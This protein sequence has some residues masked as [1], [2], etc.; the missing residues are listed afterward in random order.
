MK[1]GVGRT[2]KSHAVASQLLMCNNHAVACKLLLGNSHA[3][4]WQ[5]LS[6]Y[7]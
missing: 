2:L 4:A 3:V 1:H 7:A 5:Q 6:S